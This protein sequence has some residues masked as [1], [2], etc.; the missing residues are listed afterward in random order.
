MIQGDQQAFQ[1]MSPFPGFG[2]IILGAAGD[3]LFLEFKIMIEHLLQVQQ[4]GPHVNQSQHVDAEGI[5]QLGMLVQLIQDNMGIGIPL[6][7]NRNQ[8]TV[9]VGQIFDVRNADDPFFLYHLGN[10]LHQFGLVDLIGQFRY[11][12]SASA[13]LFLDNLSSCPDHQFAA[14]GFIGFPD[15]G[16]TVNDTTGGEIRSLDVMQQFQ[17][18]DVGLIDHGDDAVDGLTQVV[19]WN[20]CRHADGNADGAVDQ[21]VGVAGRKHDGLF[22]I[23]VVIGPKINRLLFNVADHFHRQLVHA[24]LGITLSRRAVA[25][26]GTE[27]ALAVDQRIAER[28]RL[29]H[30]YQCVVDGGVAVGMVFTHDVTDDTGAFLVGLVRIHAGFVHSE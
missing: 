5:L 25:V 14:A 12:Y 15:A 7:F 29:G 11:F 24:A 17:H 19:R 16:S 21:K 2:Q 1:D 27:V 18:A 10:A 28:E 23:A 4:L 20:I 9:P 13:V 3:D 22:L 30:T 26:N 6:D 8:Q